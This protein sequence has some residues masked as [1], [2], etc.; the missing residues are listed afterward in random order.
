MT[1][2]VVVLGAIRGYSADLRERAVVAVVV[3]GMSQLLA[4]ECLGV[5]RA[6]VGCYVRAWQEEGREPG[7]RQ[8]HED[9]L[10]L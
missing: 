2:S 1:E 7:S 8:E 5:S 4:A 9:A 3:E 10:V 6:S